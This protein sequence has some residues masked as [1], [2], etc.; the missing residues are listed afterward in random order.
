MKQMRRCPWCRTVGDGFVELDGRMVCRS[1]EEILRGSVLLRLMSPFPEST[2]P[3]YDR[4]FA[5]DTAIRDPSLRST[6]YPSDEDWAKL[7]VES[8]V[9][10]TSEWSGEGDRPNGP[11]R[12]KVDWVFTWDGRSVALEVS[13]KQLPDTEGWKCEGGLEIRE[14]GAVGGSIYDSPIGLSEAIRRVLQAKRKAG[15]FPD[16]HEKWIFVYLDALYVNV[17]GVKQ[18]VWP[19]FENVFH[20]R[21]PA[22]E[23]S[24]KGHLNEITR[25][26][27]S[28]ADFYDQV[29]LARRGGQDHPWMVVRWTRDQQW[30]WEVIKVQGN[31]DNSSGRHAG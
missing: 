11:D 14:P 2:E 28:F 19:Q 5:V 30:H 12:K 17:E 7:I 26:V 18:P 15:Q 29:W 8:Y 27:Q 20:P 25:M 23:A 6:P 31:T 1:C 4:Y 21:H 9:N 13:S 22:A 3:E 24:Q 10:G 16:D